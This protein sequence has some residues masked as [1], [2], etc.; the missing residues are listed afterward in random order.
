MWNV[1]ISY[2]KHY[3]GRSQG[4]TQLAESVP[5]TQSPGSIF[6]IPH[7]QTLGGRGGGPEVQGILS[8][9]KTSLDALGPRFKHKRKQTHTKL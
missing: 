8:Y 3:V 9:F 1:Q 4:C 5:R 2:S 7:D 6:S